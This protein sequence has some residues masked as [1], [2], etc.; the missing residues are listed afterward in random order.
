MH[1]LQKLLIAIIFLAAFACSSP[2]KKEAQW[3]T[4]SNFEDVENQ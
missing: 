1:P 2:E 4:V 3:I